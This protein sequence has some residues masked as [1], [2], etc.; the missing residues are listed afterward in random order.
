MVAGGGG[1]GGVQLGGAGRCTG[2]PAGGGALRRAV[3]QSGALAASLIHAPPSQMQHEK[4]LVMGIM[5]AMRMGMQQEQ[6]SGRGCVGC[7]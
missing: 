6:Q 7:A 2:A 1:E 4:P 3:P 5:L